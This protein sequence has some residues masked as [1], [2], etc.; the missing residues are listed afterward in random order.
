MRPISASTTILVFSQVSRASGIESISH[1]DYSCTHLLLQTALQPLW[2]RTADCRV[3]D[4]SEFDA[5]H[6]LG[7][8]SMR[9]IIISS[10]GMHRRS[11]APTA[12]TAVAAAMLALALLAA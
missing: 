12:H 8:P 7:G 3:Q 9:N 6:L 1:S 5:T 4:H 2:S 11:R 10:V